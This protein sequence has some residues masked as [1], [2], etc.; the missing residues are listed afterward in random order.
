LQQEQSAVATSL[1]VHGDDALDEDD[2][3]IFAVFRRCGITAVR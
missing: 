2:G 1:M 3:D